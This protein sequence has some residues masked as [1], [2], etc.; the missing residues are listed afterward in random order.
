MD[1]TARV[2]QA[3]TEN[4]MDGRIPGFSDVSGDLVDGLPH[5]SPKAIESTPVRRG[6]YRAGESILVSITYDRPVVVVGN[7]H[8]H[9]QVGHSQVDATNRSG[10]GTSTLIFGYDVQADDRD[11]DGFALRDFVEGFHPEDTICP[12]G[13]DIPVVRFSQGF[14]SQEGYAVAGRVHVSTVEAISDP[15]EDGVYEM[16]DTIELSATFDDEVTLTGT[17]R[18]SRDLDASAR[19]AVFKEVRK[20]TDDGLTATTSTSG[21]AGNTGEVLVVTYTVQTADE[22]R[23]GITVVRDSPSLNGGAIVDPLGNE[24]DLRH[25]AMTFAGHPVVEVPPVLESART[26]QDGSQ[27]IISFSEDI[28]VRPDLQTLSAF[29]GVDVGVYLRALIDVFVNDHRARTHRAV[30]SGKDLILTMDTTIRQGRR[31]KWPTTTFSPATCPG[32]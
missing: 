6:V 10:S 32:S 17:L 7:P 2:Y 12:V 18:L 30:I 1:G 28:Q 25:R 4:Q 11:Y 26:S 29:A 22:D 24:P 27:V 3:G 21:D 31:S 9:F 13:L 16:G 8:I 20:V 5:I 23:D 15:G 19:V 14:D